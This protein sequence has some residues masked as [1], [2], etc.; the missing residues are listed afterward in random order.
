MVQT[1]P[2]VTIK[3]GEEFFASYGYSP[4]LELPWYR[5]AFNKFRKEHPE[6]GRRLMKY[7]KIH[8]TDELL[9]DGGGDEE[10]LAM[11]S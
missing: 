3:K 5:E 9:K 4:R 2:G 7:Y 1:K 6:Q 10:E 8:E 11:G